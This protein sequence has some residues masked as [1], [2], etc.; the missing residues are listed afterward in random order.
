[1]KGPK[2]KGLKDM[3]ADFAIVLIRIIVAL[4]P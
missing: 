2:H 3:V 4:I 1:M